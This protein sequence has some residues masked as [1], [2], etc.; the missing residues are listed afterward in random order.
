M[1]KIPN[2]NAENTAQETFSLISNEKLLALYSAMLKCRLLEQTATEL[3][4]HGKID[5]DLHGS[6]GREAAAAAV[7]IDLE[8]KDTLAL[9]SGDWLPAFV[10][11]FSPEMLFR[12]LAPAASQQDGA[13]SIESEHKNILLPSNSEH[14]AA[15]ANERAAAAF[16]GKDGAIVMVII[17]P[18]PESLKPWQKI[19]STAGSRRL[20]LIFMRYVDEASE[21]VPAR[22]T[23]RS[24]RPE[25]LYRGVPSIAV[26]VLDPVAIYR[27]VYEALV[28]GRQRRGATLVECTLH[29]ASGRDAAASVDPVAAMED[30]LKRKGIEPETHNRQIVADFRRDLDLATR[31][32]DR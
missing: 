18:G 29:S 21:P 28:R 30:Y 26:D 22:A 11:G 17:S 6:A 8:P 16:E 9:A 10:K 4:Q 12:M 14:Q 31:F 5:S 25:A 23:S 13:A 1:A 27:V 24:N 2:S 15:V 19:I 3:F 32:L 7:S 20:P